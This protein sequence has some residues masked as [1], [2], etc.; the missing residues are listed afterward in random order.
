[1]L[2]KT[3]LTIF[4]A[5][6]L[7]GAIG[8][9]ARYAIEL[10]LATRVTETDL[11]LTGIVNL[12]GATLLGFVNSHPFFQTLTRKMFFGHGLLGSFTTMSGLALI[13]G[14]MEM[15]LGPFSFWY[16]LFVIAQLVLGV[17]VYEFGSR[18]AKA[19]QSK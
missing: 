18:F 15:G 5:M 16:W 8:A 19:G 3:S 4:P 12:L 17:L 14:G 1:M 10:G 2:K 11:W 6:I 7:G 13:T 9:T